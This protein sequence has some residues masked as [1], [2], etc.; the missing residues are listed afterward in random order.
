MVRDVS[1]WQSNG[2]RQRNP[3]YSSNVSVGNTNISMC[4]KLLKLT[5]LGVIDLV[6]KKNGWKQQWLWRLR[7]QEQ[8]Q[9][10]K[11]IEPHLIIKQQQA[12]LLLEYLSLPVGNGG[13]PVPEEIR[14]D[15]E[16][17]FEELAIL[18]QR[19]DC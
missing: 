19:G 5:Q 17:I 18:N 2:K 16:L 11:M 3:T 8:E 6:A 9:F 1:D 4:A 7:K 13:M 15:R 12:R 10:L 14:I